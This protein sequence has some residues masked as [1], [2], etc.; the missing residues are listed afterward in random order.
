MEVNQHKLEAIR[1]KIWH[2]TK[3]IPEIRFGNKKIIEAFRLFEPKHKSVIVNYFDLKNRGYFEPKKAKNLREELG[4]PDAV[5][6]SSVGTDRSLDKLS[7]DEY[8]KAAL[9]IKA[10][11]VTTIDDYIYLIDNEYPQ[12]QLRNFVRAKSRTRKLL[13]LSNGSYTVFGLVIGKDT[14]QIQDYMKFLANCGIN[15]F[16][17]PCGDLLKNNSPD[18]KLIKTFLALAKDLGRWNLLL[19][20]NSIKILSKL[21]FDC[22]S[23]NQWYFDAVHNRVYKNQKIV[24]ARKINIDSK[25]LSTDTDTT[26]SLHNLNECHSFSMNFGGYDGRNA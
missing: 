22:Y 26:L 5:I 3:F 25:Y 12:F 19:G 8:H 7:V 15:D 13:E 9:M 16:V 18:L 6:L 1:P 23:T 20:I 17:F 14:N 24:D 11:A 21:E 10:D 4:F 2:R